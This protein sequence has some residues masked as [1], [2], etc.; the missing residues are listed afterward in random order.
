[1]KYNDVFSSKSKTFGGLH[2]EDKLLVI[3]SVTLATWKNKNIKVN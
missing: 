1:M 2:T 3:S